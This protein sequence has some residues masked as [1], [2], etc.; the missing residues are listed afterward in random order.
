MSDPDRFDPTRFA[1]ESEAQTPRYQYMPFGAGP[2]ICVG[3]AF[4]IIEAV[5]ILAT[6]VRAASFA[7][8]PGHEPEAVSRITLRPAGGMPLMVRMR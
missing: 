4:A 7:T 6:L 5:A 3:M 1:P 8:T 2:R